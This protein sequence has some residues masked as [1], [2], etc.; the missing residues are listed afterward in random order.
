[1]LGPPCC[2]AGSTCKLHLSAPPGLLLCCSVLLKTAATL[3]KINHLLNSERKWG[4]LLFGNFHCKCPSSHGAHAAARAKFLPLPSPA[5]HLTQCPNQNEPHIQRTRSQG[6]CLVERAGMP[7]VKEQTFLMPPMNMESGA[8]VMRSRPELHMQGGLGVHQEAGWMGAGLIGRGGI[9]QGCCV[10]GHGGVLSRQGFQPA[11]QAHACSLHLSSSSL[12]SL[13]QASCPVLRR[14]PADHVPAHESLDGT[15]TA[16]R[17][18]LARPTFRRPFPRPQSQAD[19]AGPPDPLLLPLICLVLAPSSSSASRMKR[20]PVQ[21]QWK[22]LCRGLRG[23]QSMPM[24]AGR[25]VG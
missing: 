15:Q 6:P 16:I 3:E 18:M 8:C 14:L 21:L 22:P 9:R 11:R 19:C 10:E 1:M 23:M 12:K 17:S 4:Q 24:A 20:H 13:L 25:G 5:F 2:L 7:C